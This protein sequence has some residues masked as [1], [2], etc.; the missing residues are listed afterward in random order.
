MALSVALTL[1][2]VWTSIALSV[3]TDLPIG[4]FATAIGALL[5]AGARLAARRRRRREG[6]SRMP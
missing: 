5:Y 1:G 2:T 4:F 6:R 3:G